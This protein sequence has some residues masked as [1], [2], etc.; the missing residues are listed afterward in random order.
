MLDSIDLALCPTAA[1][2]REGSW[3]ALCPGGVNIGGRSMVVLYLRGCTG[4][5]S[6][7]ESSA[8]EQ[9]WSSIRFDWNLGRRIV[10]I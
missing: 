4:G 5:A 1:L 9:R 8:R 10:C 7:G 2:W 6:T 3:G